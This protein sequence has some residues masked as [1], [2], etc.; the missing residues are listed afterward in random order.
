MDNI[1]NNR[2]IKIS[3]RLAPDELNFVKEKAKL[4]GSKNLSCYLRK[5]AIAGMVINYN[6]EMLN[7][8]KKDIS[9]IGTNINQ[10]ALRVNKT[11]TIYSDDIKEIKEKVEETWRSLQSIQSALRLTKQ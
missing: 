1:N 2:M 7:E 3:F 11:N 6:D 9:G 5:M 10:I 4:S 8:M